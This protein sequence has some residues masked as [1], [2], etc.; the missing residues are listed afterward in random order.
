MNG[1][2][3][4]FTNDDVHKFLAEYDVLCISESHFGIRSKCP[5][6][7]TL[8]ARSKKVESKSPRGGVAVF[9]NNTC[10]I[11]LEVLY[12]EFQDC[13]ICRILNTDVLLVAM[14]IPPSNSIYFDDKYFTNLDVIFN[15]FKSYQLIIMGDLNS[16]L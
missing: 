10:N 3:N 6:D 5:Q 8:V 15:V 2:K 9:R 13:V 11:D 1:V 4:K 12:D 7:F 14:Y 16:L